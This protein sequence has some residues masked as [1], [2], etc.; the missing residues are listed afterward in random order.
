MLDSACHL[1]RRSA[2]TL[3]RI[4]HDAIALAARFGVAGVFWQSARTKVEGLSISD[5]TFLLFR[6]EY[7]LPLIPPD[8]AAV[9][10]TVSEHLL[11]VLL[12]VGLATRLSAAAL[13]GMTLVIQ[14]FVYPAAWPTHLTWA[15]SFLYLMARGG[16]RFALDSVFGRRLSRQAGV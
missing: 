2:E 16:G 1:G 5:T 3:E 14:V 6:E 7:R 13:L 11:A 4:P 9:A 15:A 8:I 12:A 10:A